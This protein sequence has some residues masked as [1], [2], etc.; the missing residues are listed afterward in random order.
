MDKDSERLRKQESARWGNTIIHL[1]QLSAIYSTTSEKSPLAY[2]LIFGKF[3]R[4]SN[5]FCEVASKIKLKQLKLKK[6]IKPMEFTNP[7]IKKY[8][9]L[10]SSEDY[11][12]NDIAYTLM[13]K[14]LDLKNW[15]IEDLFILN[16]F[17][18]NTEAKALLK[19]KNQVSNEYRKKIMDELEG[20]I[21]NISYEEQLDIIAKLFENHFFKAFFGY[22]LVPYKENENT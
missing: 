12:N 7:I 18:C 20:L 22:E 9:E 5:A 8:E 2:S 16:F 11:V 19:D 1:V 17:V 4:F 14:E 13:Y 6:N 3:S 15:S 10:M 21:K